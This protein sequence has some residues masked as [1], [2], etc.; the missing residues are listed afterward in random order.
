MPLFFRRPVEVADSVSMSPVRRPG[1][2]TVLTVP[3]ESVDVVDSSWIELPVTTPS[4]EMKP[5][6]LTRFL[7][8]FVMRI[9][10]ESV[11]VPELF[12]QVTF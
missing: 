5:S 7:D 12:P 11:T 1:P 4:V 2:Y 3:Y 9:T 6:N 10:P 8:S